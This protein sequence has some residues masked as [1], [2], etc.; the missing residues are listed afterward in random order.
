MADPQHDF[1]LLDRPWITVVAT[2]G[3]RRQIGILEAFQNAH[4]IREVSDPSPLATAGIYRLLFTV[5]QRYDPLPAG[6][7][8]IDSWAENWQRGRFSSTPVDRIAAGCT[9]RFSLFDPA[10]P[11]FQTA[12]APV[13]PSAVMRW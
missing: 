1:D 9:G 13:S 8:W 11:F 10:R 3:Q 4:Q 2:G 6:E 7:E 12:D 5:L